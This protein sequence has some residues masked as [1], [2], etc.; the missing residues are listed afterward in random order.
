MIIEKTIEEISKMVDLKPEEIMEFIDDWAIPLMTKGIIVKLNIKRWRGRSKIGPE[1]LGIEKDNEEWEVFSDEY[2]NYGSKV[3]LP[4]RIIRRMNNIE[5]LARRNI[6]E[7]SFDTVWGPFIPCSVF[8]EWKIK[9]EEIRLRYYAEAESIYDEYDEIIKEVIDSYKKFAQETY[10]KLKINIDYEEYEKDFILNIEREI[11]SKENFWDTIEYTSL[12]YY[13]PLPS[14]IKEEIYDAEQIEKKIEE[15][16]SE[17]KMRDIVRQEATRKKTEYID[18]FLDATVG[19]IREMILEIIGDVKVGVNIERN[20]FSA[21]KNRKKLLGM[22]E[23]IRILDFYNDSEIRD[24]LDKLQ[25]DLEKEKN[26]RSNEEIYNS[27]E[28]LEN[29]AKSGII[30]LIGGKKLL[31]I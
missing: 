19:K 6:K 23:K 30:K 14:Q 31:E 25:L 5:N 3:L 10:R 13:I 20:E 7:Y 11:L 8:D 28:E 18:H 29:V 9:N 26:Y 2:I 22:I 21:D 4:K 17:K 16:E 15:S 1:E 12:Y 27:L 24:S